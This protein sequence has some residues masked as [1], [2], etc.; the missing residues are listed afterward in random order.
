MMEHGSTVSSFFFSL[1]KIASTEANPYQ[2]SNAQQFL[3]IPGECSTRH[4]L[5][6]YWSFYTG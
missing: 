6:V 4:M 5:P 1:R 2:I 3:H